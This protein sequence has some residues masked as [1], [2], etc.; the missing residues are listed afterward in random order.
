MAERANRFLG[1][2]KNGGASH[3]FLFHLHQ[4]CQSL[5]YNEWMDAKKTRQRLPLGIFIASFSLFAGLWLAIRFVTSSSSF[6]ASWKIGLLVM[7]AVLCLLASIAGILSI[8]LTLRRPVPRPPTPLIVALFAYIFP[9]FA[10]VFPFWLATRFF[11]NTAGSMPSLLISWLQPAPPW[12][13]VGQTG[14]LAVAVVVWFLLPGKVWRNILPLERPIWML[15]ILAGVGLWLLATFASTLISG[16]AFRLFS[17]LSPAAAPTLDT[18]PL[19][20]F[21]LAV[22]VALV[23]APPAEEYLFRHLLIQ[24]WQPRLGTLAAA[25]ASSALFAT[26]LGRPL[27]WV[28]AFLLGMGLHTLT[29]TTGHLRAAIFAHVIFNILALCVNWSAIL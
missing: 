3:H 29:E 10:L 19:P 28:P 27:L 2:T 12:L 20:A 17:V 9:A 7:A 18:I 14:L 25:A 26:L 1:E 4:T 11:S 22:F 24:S 21:S 16:L 15:G 6:S 13:F 5:R 23:I 8:F